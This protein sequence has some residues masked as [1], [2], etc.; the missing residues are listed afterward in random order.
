MI[1]LNFS[2][3]KAEHQGLG[4]K[5][6]KGEKSLFSQIL[7][8]YRKYVQETNQHTSHVPDF[9]INKNQWRIFKENKTHATIDFY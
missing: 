3:N 6:V 4:F 7:V 5:S 8:K 1:F 9:N 2:R